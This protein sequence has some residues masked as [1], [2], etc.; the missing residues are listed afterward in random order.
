MPFSIGVN[1][2]NSNSRS[3][4]YGP[5]IDDVQLKINY[6]YIPPIDEGTQDVIDDIDQ[7]IIDISDKVIKL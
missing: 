1:V 3:G 4:H 5:D 2:S 7:D 6:T